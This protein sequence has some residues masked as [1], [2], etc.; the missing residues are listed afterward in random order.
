[1]NETQI[2]RETR[3]VVED[4]LEKTNLKQGVLFVLGLS[5][6]EVLGGQIGKESSQ[7]IGELIVETILGIRGDYL[8]YSR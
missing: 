5:S 3:Q 7:E 2:Q 8:G 4:V 6:S 1:M